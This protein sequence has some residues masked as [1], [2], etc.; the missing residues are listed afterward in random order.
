[1]KA[2]AASTAGISGRLVG[3]RA[4]RIASSSSAEC[5]S[6]RT[7]ELSAETAKPTPPQAASRRAQGELEV[8]NRL[9]QGADR[10]EDEATG[11]RDCRRPQAE[12]PGG[13]PDRHRV[14]V[15]DPGIGAG[16]GDEPDDE[17]ED[18]GGAGPGDP[19]LVGHQPPARYLRWV[20]AGR[21]DRADQLQLEAGGDSVEEP[22]AATEQ[23]RS[24]VEDPSRRPGRR[25]GT[26]RRRRRRRR[27]RR[28][29][30][31]PRALAC[32]RADSIPSVTKWKVVPP[33]ISSGSR[34]WWVRTKTGAWKGGSS[35]H[36]PFQAGPRPRVRDRRRTCC[37][38]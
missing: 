19:R 28:P 30:P 9:E 17:D 37:G 4:A 1:M 5:S 25:P 16:I 18:G 3:A 24:D 6:T 31:R 21:V 34:S 8:G 29:C 32:S 12:P 38:P 33:S 15:A 26:G 22:L 27:E 13:H 10:V 11:H 35:P 36:Q 20:T 14:E 2:A 23:D 7:R